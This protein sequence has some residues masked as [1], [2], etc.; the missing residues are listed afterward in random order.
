MVLK[1]GLG[2]QRSKRSWST[3][4]THTHMHAH[5]HAHTPKRRK[6]D[7]Q[8][9]TTV[10][11]HSVAC[12]P[13]RQHQSLGRSPTPVLAAAPWAVSRPV[14]LSE[15]G[16]EEKRR[17]KKLKFPVECVRHPAQPHLFWFNKL[18]AN[19]HGADTFTRVCTLCGQHNAYGNGRESMQTIY[20]VGEEINEKYNLRKEEERPASTHRPHQTSCTLDVPRNWRVA[21]WDFRSSRM[22]FTAFCSS[23]S[24]TFRICSNSGSDDDILL[25]GT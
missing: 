20:Y 17:K 23:F 2:R 21:C 7:K 13:W 12:S 5:A 10:G 15:K 25:L 22:L 4:H 18:R 9:K 19:V 3:A 14:R 6:E 1:C 8:K 16:R 11:H 24:L